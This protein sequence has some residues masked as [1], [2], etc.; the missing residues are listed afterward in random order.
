MENDR[1]LEFI[2]NKNPIIIF[3]T[4][5]W[6]DIY[7]NLPETIISHVNVL[8]EKFFKDRLFIPYYVNI[9]FEKNYRELI[10][11]HKKFVKRINDNIYNI[12]K[13]YK[14][15]IFNSID[16]A[17]KR[18]RIN[19]NEE[20]ESEI[21]D[22][23]N[24]LCTKTKEFI[25]LNNTQKDLVDSDAYNVIKKCFDNY[26]NQNKIDII[27]KEEFIN[28]ILEGE[29]RYTEKIPPGYEDFSKGYSGRFIYGDLIIWKEMI[30]YAKL[31]ARNILFVTNDVKRD[32]FTNDEFNESLVKEFNSETSKDIIGITGERFIDFIN[33]SHLV[34]GKITNSVDDYIEVNIDKFCS[35]IEAEVYDFV[36]EEVTNDENRLFSA[37]D[38]IGSYTGDYYES[39]G[40]NDIE[41]L[42]STYSRDEDIIEIR[43]KLKINFDVFTK[44]YWGKDEDTK[45]VVLSPKD[46]YMCIS[47]IVGHPSRR[48]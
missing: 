28:I 12:S 14:R 38:I 1:I 2:N 26:Y 6:L 39:N 40:V 41:I 25:L 5:I 44:S 19:N 4:N 23:L 36:N 11:E 3:D 13:E 29:N 42:S 37:Y 22:L 20:I 32:W 17:K 48:L 43:M 15:K 31:N 47:A 30:K 45:E 18:Y 21:G 16:N 34:S 46:E 24:E 33:N 27:T 10:G 9:E 35:L 7:R 8:E